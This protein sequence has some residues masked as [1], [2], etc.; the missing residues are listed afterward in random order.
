[1]VCERVAHDAHRSTARRCRLGPHNIHYLVKAFAGQ[2]VGHASRRH[3]G[4]EPQRM[5]ALHSGSKGMGGF[6]ASLLS[7]CS[8]KT[9]DQ[10]HH[11][12]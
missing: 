4:Q 2:Q 6:C 3:I 7:T 9:A 1:M 12:D 5:V 10:V 11:F 8:N